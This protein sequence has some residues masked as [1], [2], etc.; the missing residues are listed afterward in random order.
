MPKSS[1]ELT[2]W[3]VAAGALAATAVLVSLAGF[4]S[5]RVAILSLAAFALAGAV[6]RVVAPL[7]RAFIVRRRLV[8]VSVLLILGGVLAYLGFTTPLG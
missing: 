2:S 4:V 5:A 6:A 8:D 7:R 3:R 1:P